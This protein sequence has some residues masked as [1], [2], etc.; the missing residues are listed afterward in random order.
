MEMKEHAL[1]NAPV[2]HHIL[3]PVLEVSCQ[4]QD[5]IILFTS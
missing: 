3:I 5:N 2:Q 1:D 4:K